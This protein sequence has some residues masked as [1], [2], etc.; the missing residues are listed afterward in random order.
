M[1]SKRIEIFKNLRF[2][3]KKTSI[4]LKMSLKCQAFLKKASNSQKRATQ[5]LTHSH[6]G[7]S[8]L[9]LFAD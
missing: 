5:Q 9:E 1:A 7:Q 4:S 3:L 6:N 2:T 8:A